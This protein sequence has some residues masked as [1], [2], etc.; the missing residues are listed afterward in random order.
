MFWHFQSLPQ[1][2]LPSVGQLS[3]QSFLLPARPGLPLF[4]PPTTADAPRLSESE[5]VLASAVS[6]RPA[7]MPPPPQLAAV[8]SKPIQQQRSR[9]CFITGSPVERWVYLYLPQPV[10]P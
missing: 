4:P 2:A 6:L 7:V 1:P 9:R 3:L 5:S 10:R 8:H